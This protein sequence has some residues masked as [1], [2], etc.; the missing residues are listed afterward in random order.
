M[1]K[2]T[3]DTGVLPADDLIEAAEP[4]GCEFVVVS[5]TAR[6]VADTPY[7]VRLNDCGEIL[8]TA[9][10]GESYWGKSE[11]GTDQSPD[12][13]DKILRIISNGAFPVSREN[14]S[15]GQR[16]QLRDAMILEAHIRAHRNI[17][18]TDDTKAFVRGGRREELAAKFRVRI[19]VREEFLAECRAGT[20]EAV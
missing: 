5:V 6:E 2:V 15:D 12:V 17:F 1:M 11:F 16:H 3:L 20:L 18:V 4:F 9:V 10:W 7:E 19:L 14:L 8:E 13:L